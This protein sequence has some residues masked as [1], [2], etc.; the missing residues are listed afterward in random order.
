MMQ[1][2]AT[3]IS[4]LKWAVIVFIVLTGAVAA[5]LGWQNRDSEKVILTALPAVALGTI[6]VLLTILFGLKEEIRETEF[7][8][9]F[10]YERASL[11]PLGL[12]RDIGYLPSSETWAS[13]H[14]QEITTAHPDA[15]TKDKNSPGMDMYGDIALR[16]VF[17]RLFLTFGKTWDVKIDKRDLPF[18]GGGSGGYDEASKSDLIPWSKLSGFFPESYALQAPPIL[19]EETSE[20]GIPVGTKLSGE[21]KRNSSGGFA[22]AHIC[23]VNDFVD[24]E[25]KIKLRGGAA[26]IGIYSLVAHLPQH[27]SSNVWTASYLISMKAKLKAYRSG[28]PDMPKYQAWVDNVFETVKEQLDSRMEWERTKETVTLP[29]TRPLPMKKSS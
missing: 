25:I 7:P 2:E 4:A 15:I 14:L 5:W 16:L 23:M 26:G 24:L 22:Q 10:T 13:M 19:F 28:H 27:E 9:V 18:L 11:I 29:K 20:L 1:G 8:A 17:D 21:V 3:V 6:G 12:A